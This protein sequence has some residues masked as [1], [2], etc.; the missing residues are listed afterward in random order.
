MRSMMDKDNSLKE[1]LKKLLL[2][3]LEKSKR[4]VNLKIDDLLPILKEEEEILEELGIRIK[5]PLEEDQREIILE[6]DRINQRNKELVKRSLFFLEDFFR[7][8]NSF[9]YKG[10]YGD[11]VRKNSLVINQIV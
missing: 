5:F 9:E 11:R 3:S 10:I 7:F 6:L 4:L 2:L 1:Y 8:I